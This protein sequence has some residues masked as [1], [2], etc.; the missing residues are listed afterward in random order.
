VAL[1]VIPVTRKT[2]VNPP[3]NALPEIVVFQAVMVT[4]AVTPSLDRSVITAVPL[5]VLPETVP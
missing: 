3:D 4:L 2:I 1:P 5:S